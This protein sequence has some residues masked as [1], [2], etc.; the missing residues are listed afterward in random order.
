MPSSFHEV[1]QTI[2]ALNT[3]EDMGKLAVCVLHGHSIGGGLQLAL[4]CDVRIATED[5]VI[6]LG[7]T[8][9]GLIPDG[10]VLRLAR[11]VGLG[12]ATALALLNDEV[13]PAEALAIGLVTRVCAAGELEGTLAAVLERCRAAAPTATG[14]TKRLL[15]ASF[16]RDPR[17]LIEELL[18]RQAEC[19]TSWE[20][21][22]ANAAWREKRA[23]RFFPRSEGRA[24]R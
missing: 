20:M 13:A 21:E 12:R 15:H 5:A 8:R 23:A 6:G 22:E 17:E 7:A 24:P 1:A 11:V 4:A 2:R 10:G 3:L 9:H 16:H 19:M 14:H 18:R